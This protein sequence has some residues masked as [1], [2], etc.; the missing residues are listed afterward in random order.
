MITIIVI[1]IL[2][3]AVILTIANNNPI[4]NANKATFQNDL[5]AMEEEVNLYESE[6]YAEANIEDQ[7]YTPT[8]VE[9]QEMV[10]LFPSTSGY[11]DKVKVE[12]GKLVIIE[13]TLS[14]KE[15]EWASEI[16]LVAGG[17]LASTPVIPTGFRY[18]EGT[19]DTGYVIVDNSGT[20]TD[21]NEF[22]WV[23]VPEGT[24]ERE[25][26][27]HITWEYDDE[28]NLIG[29]SALQNYVSSKYATEPYSGASEEEKAEYSAMKTSVEKYGGFYIG[30]YEASID[31][32]G[33]AQS[34]PNQ[35][36]V[37]SIKWGNS[38]TDLNGGAVEKARAVYPES[39]ATNGDGVST[40]VYGVQWDATVRWLEKRYQGIA[41]N[42][43]EFGN[44][45]SDLGLVNTGSNE[46]YK[47][48]N[49]YD[50][51]GNLWE[52]T[53]EAYSSDGRGRVARGSAYIHGGDIQPIS[54]RFSTYPTNPGGDRGFRLAL[55]IK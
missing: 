49:I 30:R 35:S 46:Q 25:D 11:E 48:N 7:T 26:G 52:W 39:E 14:E 37:A 55:Y 2:A 36:P 40:L 8:T 53:M 18:L 10:S 27:Y 21:G 22:V 23:P 4:E 47:T 28:W 42:I 17:E 43:T 12:N 51:C 38:M 19:V 31:A 13:D 41:E 32:S 34:K 6:K 20:S 54:C 9:G 44:Y 16:G 50:M 3:V 29:N 15:K 33:K 1:I 45:D 24:F 5:K